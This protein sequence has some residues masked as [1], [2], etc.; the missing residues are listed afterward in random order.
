MVTAPAVVWLFDIVF[1]FGSVRA[2]VRKRWP[3]YAG[4]AATWLVLAVVVSSGLRM[5]SAG[6][7]TKVTPWT[8]LLNQTVM[9]PRYL[10]LTVWPRGLVVAYGPVPSLTLAAVWPY[11]AIVVLAGAA[12]V[13]ALLRSPLAGFVG[14]WVFMTRAA[15]SRDRAGGA[16]FEA[17]TRELLQARQVDAPNAYSS[18]GVFPV[19]RATIRAR[20]VTHNDATTYSEIAVVV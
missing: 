7:A 2:A 8:Y 13:A 1:V 19:S 9:I 5:Y 12:T 20:P 11:A 16:A 3:L 15:K 17:M 10:K 6:F 18:S 14:A 4:L